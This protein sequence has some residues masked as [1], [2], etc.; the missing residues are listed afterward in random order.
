MVTAWP[1]VTILRG[2]VV[3]QDG[4]FHGDLRTGSSS[5]ARSPTTYAAGP[6]CRACSGR[7][8]IVAAQLALAMAG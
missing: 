7:T 2:K 6:P 8:A 4:A 5:S 3:V 1:T